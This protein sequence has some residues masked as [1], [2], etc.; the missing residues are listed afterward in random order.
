MKLKKNILNRIIIA[1]LIVLASCSSKKVTQTS[2]F[3]IPLDS[4]FVSAVENNEI[5]G[6]VIQIV[7]SCYA[8]KSSK[9]LIMQL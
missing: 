3:N 1:S 5:P 9:R 2:E 6:A 7:N 4:L 8:N